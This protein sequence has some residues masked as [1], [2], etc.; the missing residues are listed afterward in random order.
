M[1]LPFPIMKWSYSTGNSLGNFI[2]VW[3]IPE[4]PET[5]SQSEDICI[6]GKL[7]KL[8][9]TFSTM[10]RRYNRVDH[11]FSQQKGRGASAEERPEHDDTSRHATRQNW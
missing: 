8:I 2:C 6:L 9:P 4:D 10:A 3:R 7:Q 5:R 1:Q 11:L